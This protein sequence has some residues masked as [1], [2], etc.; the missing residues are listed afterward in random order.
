MPMCDL[1][2]S[3]CVSFLV[4]ACL[5]GR[6]GCYAC[7]RAVV[8]ATAC[9]R[10]WEVCSTRACMGIWGTGLRGVSLGVLLQVGFWFVV[11]D[12]VMVRLFVDTS[13]EHPAEKLGYLGA[14][15]ATVELVLLQSL[16][17]FRGLVVAIARTSLHPT[18]HESPLSS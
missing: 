8:G 16:L 10:A 18:Y 2:S 3:F 6:F 12:C 9:I 15:N 5:L 11:L 17:S 7:A 14:L 4:E 13:Q 1:Q